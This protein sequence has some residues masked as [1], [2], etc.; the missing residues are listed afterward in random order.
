MPGTGSSTT[1]KYSR[2]PGVNEALERLER[3]DVRHRLV[4]DLSDPDRS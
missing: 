4:L 2:R 3:G 1:W